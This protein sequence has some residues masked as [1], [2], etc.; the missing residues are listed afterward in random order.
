MSEKVAA[1]YGKFSQAQQSADETTRVSRPGSRPP[2][3]RSAQ[4]VIKMH[5]QLDWASVVLLLKLT[6]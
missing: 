6:V 5:A 1:G 3:T 2:H 4:R